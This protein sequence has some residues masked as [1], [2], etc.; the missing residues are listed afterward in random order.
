[1][2]LSHGLMTVLT[3]T[4][5]RPVNRFPCDAWKRA[6]SRRYRLRRKS[7]TSVANAF[8]ATTENRHL[9]QKCPDFCASMR[10]VP[11]PMTQARSRGCIFLSF[12]PPDESQPGP[13]PGPG[14]I[15]RLLWLFDFLNAFDHRGVF[16]TVLVPHR[17]DGILEGFFVGV[18]D[19]NNLDPGGLCLVQRLLFVNFPKLALLLLSLV[20]E[21]HQQFLFLLGQRVPDLFREHD[22]LRHNQVL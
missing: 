12:R 17:F 2:R 20:A 15:F 3:A 19:L 4:A 14:R 1:M 8:I 11:A 7:D 5:K 21:F 10:F 13:P 16:W 6:R 18:R 22:N 9:Q